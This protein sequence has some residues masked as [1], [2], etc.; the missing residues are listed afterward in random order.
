MKL[1][2]KQEKGT[3][4]FVIER[5][6]LATTGP[7]PPTN[8]RP[9]QWEEIGPRTYL[10]IKGRYASNHEGRARFDFVTLTNMLTAGKHP[11]TDVVVLE[12]EV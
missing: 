6:I 2:L 8:D 12:A 7:W 11:S 5:Y 1:R 9:G 3:L 10:N 4:D